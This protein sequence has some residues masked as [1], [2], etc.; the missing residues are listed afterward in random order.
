MMSAS[1]LAEAIDSIGAERVAA[2]IAEPVVGAGGVHL[3]PS[4]Y[5]DEVARICADRDVLL[6]AD[7]VVT[8][9]GRTGSMFASETYGFEADMVILAKGVTSGYLPLGAVVCSSRV[10]RPFW[11]GAPRGPLRHGYTYS[12]HATAC[13]AALANLDL[14]EG[15]DL[16]GRVASLAPEFA[17]SLET[18]CTLPAVEEVRCV[19]L[20]GGVQLDAEWIAEQGSSTAAVV[21]AC[22]ER[23]VLT[24]ALV[25]DVLQVTPPFVVGNEQMER[26]TTV[27]GEAAGAAMGGVRGEL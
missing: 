26:I 22:R 16:V 15:E 7:E 13:A 2:F 4:G 6:I 8:G 20:M 5:L 27:I 10:A 18:L 12:G 24:R 14:I 25:G 19:G 1:G 11:E 9:L 17:A 3:P 23:G 21:T